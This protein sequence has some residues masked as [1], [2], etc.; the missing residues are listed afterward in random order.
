MCKKKI[1]SPSVCRNK[2]S[3][4][5]CLTESVNLAEPRLQTTVRQLGF[6]SSKSSTQHTQWWLKLI[7]LIQNDAFDCTI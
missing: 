5:C 1:Q 7:I 2:R 4:P 3:N 6:E